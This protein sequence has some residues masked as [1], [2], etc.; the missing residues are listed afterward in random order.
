MCPHV[1]DVARAS[2][3]ARDMMLLDN[4]P[5]HAI[6]NGTNAPTSRKVKR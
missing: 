3:H 2:Q 1:H 6:P 5:A 4:D